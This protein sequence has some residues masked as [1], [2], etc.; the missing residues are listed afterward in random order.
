MRRTTGKKEKAASIDK[1]LRHAAEDILA[2][3]ASNPS[4]LESLDQER[5]L[6]EMQVHQIE[7]ELQNDELTVVKDEAEA[8]AREF[9][10]LYDFAPIGYVTLSPEGNMLRVNLTGARLLG[11]ERSNLVGAKL[12]SWVMP[13]SL[14]EFNAFFKRIFIS[15]KSETCE[16]ELAKN[17]KP[18]LAAQLQGGLSPDGKEC[19]LAVIDISERRKAE[20]CRKQAEKKLAYREAMYRELVQNANSAIIR[21]RKD[22]TITFFN[23]YA[24]RFFGYQVHEVLD[25]HVNML[26]P[27]MDSIGA[28]LSHLMR[29]ILDCPERYHKNINENVRKDGRPCLDELVQQAHPGRTRRSGRSTRCRLRHYRRHTCGNLATRKAERTPGKPTKSWRVS[30]IPCPTI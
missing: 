23:E 26:I 25:K 4:S 15:E 29:S 22:G 10:D 1:M 17:G 7:L 27:E 12:I 16:I 11:V 6:H 28:D 21:W 3:R 9:L 18:A 24:Q 5:L 20:E 8:L 19:R 2:N 14:P 30:A 13:E